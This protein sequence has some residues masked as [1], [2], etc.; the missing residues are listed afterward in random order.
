MAATAAKAADAAAAGPAQSA[1]MRG[2]DMALGRIA[3]V[4][5]ARSCDEPQLALRAC[6]QRQRAAGAHCDEAAQS[7]ARWAEAL[8]FCEEATLPFSHHPVGC[9]FSF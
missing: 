6:L 1:G 9:Q 7:C 5:Q 4:M 2:L 3:G 8:R